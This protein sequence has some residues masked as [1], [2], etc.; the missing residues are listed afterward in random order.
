MRAEA[1]KG[2]LDALL[3]AALEAGPAHGFAVMAEVRR[4][5]GGSV[6]LESGTL[7]PALRRLE[8]AGLIA[9]AWTS[10]SGRRRREY[11]LTDRGR[12]SLAD[13]RTAWRDFVDTLGAAINPVINSTTGAGF[14]SARV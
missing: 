9:G 14:P 10:G 8:E 5:T 4:R 11:E 3:L 12:I 6:D 2:H 13:K 7:Y 1:L